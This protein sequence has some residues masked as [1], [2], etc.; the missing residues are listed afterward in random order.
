MT[1]SIKSRGGKLNPMQATVDFD[2]G[3]LIIREDDVHKDSDVHDGTVR[4]N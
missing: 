1:L 4:K 3:S 2:C